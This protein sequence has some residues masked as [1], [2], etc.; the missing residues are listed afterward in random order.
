MISEA[1]HLAAE[2]R[3]RMRSLTLPCAV[4]ARY[5]AAT[6]MITVDLNRGYSVSFHKSRSQALHE[7]TDKQLSEID[8]GYPGWSV[9]FPKL[10]DGFT[11]SG[12]LAGRFGNRH[13]EKKWADEHNVEIAENTLDERVYA[14]MVERTAAEL[15][16][17]SSDVIF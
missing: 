5:D 17:D 7:A 2:E 14:V 3:G 13:W 9:F 12:M 6:G 11:V 16:Q 10:D 15:N 8:A 4:A 1:E